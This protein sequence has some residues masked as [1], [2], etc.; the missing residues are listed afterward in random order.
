MSTLTTGLFAWAAFAP[1][2][3]PVPP[4]PAPDPVAKAAIGIAADQ[5]TL[6]I[7]TV[8]PL[9]PGGRAGLRS[10]DRIVRVGSLHPADFTQVV[11]HITSYR[12]GA[13]VEMEVERAGARKVVKMKLVARPTEYDNPNR[14]PGGYPIIPADD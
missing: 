6:H 4:D 5:N 7:T 1:V 2:L 11:A 9:M 8:Y 10:G 14:F 13:I 12:P 3:A